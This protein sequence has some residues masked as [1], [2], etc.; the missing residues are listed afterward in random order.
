MIPGIKIHAYSYICV[1]MNKFIHQ[2]SCAYLAIIILIR[3]MAM[4]IS[5]LDYSLNQRFIVRNLC[6]N[7]FNT[8]LQCSGKCFLNKQ[9]AKS[10]EGQGSSE[11]K[12]NS[13]NVVIDFFQPIEKLSF[14]CQNNHCAHNKTFT[15]PRLIHS[16]TDNIFHPPIHTV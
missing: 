12:G 10:N 4:P 15:S 3:I 14:D 2:V 6:E 8:A 11:Q 13:R 7:R 1:S 16:Y 9:L 5:L